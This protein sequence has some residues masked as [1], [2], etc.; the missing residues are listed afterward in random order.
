M[1]RRGRDAGS[2]SEEGRVIEL[3]KESAGSGPAA[4]QAGSE[5]DRAA[6]LDR[7]VRQLVAGV[8]RETHFRTVYEGYSSALR[9]F[10]ARKGCS[11]EECLDLTQETFLGIYRGLRGYDHQ[12]RFEGWIYRIA[13]TTYLKRL[14][15]RSTAKRW[16]RDVSL[17]ELEQSERAPTLPG[18]QLD[19]LLL[20]ERRRTIEEAV[21]ELPPQMRKCLTLRLYHELTY[22]E[23]AVVLKLKIDTVK[24]HLFQARRKL[25]EKL[26]SDA[27]GDL[28]L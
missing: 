18:R 6:R 22:Q 25:R 26:G 7:A 1:G 11:P 4:E 19:A 17:D 12:G 8:D 23:I 14:R 24:A 2:L 9:A 10:F 3:V 21:S 5:P 16:G 27:L 13:T 15:S 28:E 20:D